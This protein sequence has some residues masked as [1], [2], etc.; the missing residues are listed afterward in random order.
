MPFPEKMTF[1]LT[2]EQTQKVSEALM[3][4]NAAYA[5]GKPGMVYA[6]IIQEDSRVYCVFKFCPQKE[7]E[8][9]IKA[10][11]KARCS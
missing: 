3:E 4:A 7:A 2:P 8:A 10:R 9:M 5:T 11:E 1:D 6:Q